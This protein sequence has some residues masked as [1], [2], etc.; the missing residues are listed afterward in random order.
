MS[1][2]SKCARLMSKLVEQED[3]LRDAN[4]QRDIYRCK[5]Q[6]LQAE[7]SLVMDDYHA[8]RAQLKVYQT[9][10]EQQS[11]TGKTGNDGGFNA[12]AVEAA[13]H[14]FLQRKNL[15]LEN[16]LLLGEGDNSTT[17]ITA[18]DSGLRD[19]EKAF[20]EACE[21]LTAHPNDFTTKESFLQ[22]DKA[23][24]TFQSD[25]QCK[26]NEG[27]IVITR[28]LQSLREFSPDGSTLPNVPKGCLPID[29]ILRAA[30]A[31]YELGSSR[32]AF[33]EDVQNF[34]QQVDSTKD[35][36]LRVA[37]LRNTLQAL[38]Q[39]PPEATAIISTIEAATGQVDEIIAEAIKIDSVVSDNNCILKHKCNRAREEVQRRQ[40]QLDKEV[41]F[42]ELG[43]QQH[44]AKVVEI[45]Q[46]IEALLSQVNEAY[47][48]MMRSAQRQRELKG[49]MS[50]CNAFTAGIQRREEVEIERQNRIKEGAKTSLLICSKVKELFRKEGEKVEEMVRKYKDSMKKTRWCV[51][52]RMYHICQEQFEDITKHGAAYRNVVRKEQQK[53]IS[54]NRIV[55]S[56]V[57]SE[58]IERRVQDEMMLASL[59]R[60][61][62]AK[63]ALA[64]ME[65]EVEAVRAAMTS[66]NTLLELGKS[67]CFLDEYDAVHKTENT[68]TKLEDLVTF[69]KSAAEL[70]LQCVD[71]E[72]PACCAAVQQ[73]LSE[74]SLC[75]L[76]LRS[77]AA[78]LQATDESHRSVASTKLRR[79]RRMIT[80]SLRD[81][82]DTNKALWEEMHVL[83]S[84]VM[85]QCDEVIAAM[86]VI[87]Q[88]LDSST[89]GSITP[90]GGSAHS[91]VRRTPSSIAS[92]R[93]GGAMMF[94]SAPERRRP[95]QHEES[96]M[97]DFSA[98][99]E[100]IEISS[101][102]TLGTGGTTTPNMTR[103]PSRT[104]S[105]IAVN[106]PSQLAPPSICPALKFG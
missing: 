88:A 15:E 13:L 66:T 98:D 9:Q 87:P 14:G 3:E 84:D 103:H 55:S 45:V 53:V 89:V 24:N 64:Q 75:L 21:S 70:M 102:G 90:V 49:V 30:H 56:G 32:E 42:C 72:E 43:I 92:A 12:V 71:G 10:Q 97:P 82:H 78:R 96:I 101:Q 95:Q 51:H 77:H 34:N 106:T 68:V 18:A 37:I 46:T 86:V 33:E 1:L 48:H 80:D 23:V 58:D 22:L 100:V 29:N 50:Q 40:A 19:V 2:E 65:H 60:M 26:N 4:A 99:Q 16:M 62:Q 27:L 39:P 6:D 28:T 61:N 17:P 93:H 67:T 91:S 79:Y 69:M 85:N 5:L 57:L 20:T 44:K 35:F 8:L 31:S 25:P 11:G 94:G 105:P 76:D 7:H 73:C 104:S 81:L 63:D 52:E 41:Q 47:I 59:G 74:C 83:V 36:A 38:N 54:A